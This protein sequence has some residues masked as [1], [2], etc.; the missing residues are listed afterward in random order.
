MSLDRF[1]EK[2]DRF[3]SEVGDQLLKGVAHRLLAIIGDRDT[4]TRWGGDEFVVLREGIKTDA[5]GSSW[6]P[7]PRLF[8]DPFAHRPGPH[9]RIRARSASRPPAPGE[10]TIDDVLRRADA[11]CQLAK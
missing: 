11:V 1:K 9:L 6:Q 8:D 4:V 7:D 3:G 10:L 2:N 5:D